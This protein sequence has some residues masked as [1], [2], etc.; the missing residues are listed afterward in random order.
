MSARL[1]LLDIVEAQKNAELL[2]LQ[3]DMEQ[4]QDKY[5]KKCSEWGVR[6]EPTRGLNKKLGY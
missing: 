3:Y 4:A 1:T 2:R 6:Q 5:A